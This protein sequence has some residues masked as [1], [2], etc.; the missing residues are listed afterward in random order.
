MN[1]YVVVRKIVLIHEVNAIEKCLH[2]IANKY[3]FFKLKF[4]CKNK[5]IQ[6]NGPFFYL[7][8]KNN[9]WSVIRRKWL[10]KGPSSEYPAISCGIIPVSSIEVHGLHIHSSG[11]LVRTFLNFCSPGLAFGQNNDTAA[12][13]SPDSWQHIHERSICQILLPDT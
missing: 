4:S 12:S 8:V 11:A 5:K 1:Q 6:L 7:Y 2:N 3:I 13:R 10:F 9:Y